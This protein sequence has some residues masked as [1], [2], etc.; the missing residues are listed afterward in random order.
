MLGFAKGGDAWEVYFGS[1]PKIKVLLV[2]LNPGSVQPWSWEPLLVACDGCARRPLAQRSGVLEKGTVATTTTDKSKQDNKYIYTT[3][4]ENAAVVNTSRGH[5][6]DSKTV[7]KDLMFENC[8]MVHDTQFLFLSTPLRDHGRVAFGISISKTQS[9]DWFSSCA[10]L[11]NERCNSQKTSRELPG[12]FL[13][14]LETRQS[15]DPPAAASTP[16]PQAAT[17]PYPLRP[18]SA[19]KSTRTG[20]GKS[21]AVVMRTGYARKVNFI[22]ETE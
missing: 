6:E 7:R 11:Y 16:P 19:N 12:G 8:S 17:T 20:C 2:L 3:Y 10:S 21:T 5:E 1:A 14:R 22:G 15:S 13:S 9:I 4:T 18:A